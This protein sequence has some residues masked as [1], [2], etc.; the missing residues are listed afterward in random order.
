MLFS[1]TVET[2][3]SRPTIAPYLAASFQKLV[4]PI[5]LFSLFSLRPTVGPLACCFPDCRPPAFRSPGCRSPGIPLSRFSVPGC[6]ALTFGPRL[7]VPG[8]PAPCFRLPAVGPPRRPGVLLS[9]SRLS[10]PA[11]R[12]SPLPSRS[13]S[14]SSPVRSTTV[15]GTLSPMPPS[16]TS[17]T[18]RP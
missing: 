5:Y 11:Q 14:G 12:S 10:A 2:A 15:V 4:F 6:P 7:S 3:S 16:M 17:S 8:C 9:A 13:T 1:T 18:S